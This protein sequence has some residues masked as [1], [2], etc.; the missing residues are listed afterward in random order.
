MAVW[1]KSISRQEEQTVQRLETSM[2]GT[3]EERQGGL[4]EQGGGWSGESKG[5]QSRRLDQK[6]S[7]GPDIAAK[8]IGRTLAFT[9]SDTESL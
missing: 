2:L 3:S 7:W 5:E 8:T 1:G 6:G 4:R 9:L